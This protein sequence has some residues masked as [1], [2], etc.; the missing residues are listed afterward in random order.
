M[1]QIPQDYRIIKSTPFYNNSNVPDILTRP[2]QI[3]TGRYARVSVMEG[4]IK[5][6]CYQQQHST[7]ADKI[8]IIRPGEFCIATTDGWYAVEMYEDDTVFTIDFFDEP[9]LTS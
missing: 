2:H 7:E 9:S 8:R 3:L 1:Q 4:A 6:F 5:L